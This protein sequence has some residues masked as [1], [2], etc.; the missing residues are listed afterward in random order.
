MIAVGVD[1][2]KQRHYAVALDHLGQMLAELTFPASAGGYQELQG[3]AEE[4]AAGR[5]LVFG[6][7]GAGSCGA[8]LCEHLRGCPAR[9]GL[10]DG[11][12]VSE[13]SQVGV[14]ATSGAAV[15]TVV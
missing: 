10:R 4:L 14:A 3:W 12:P 6:I 1:T 11:D 15:A 13:L 7:E 8:G 2:P 9:R 5:E